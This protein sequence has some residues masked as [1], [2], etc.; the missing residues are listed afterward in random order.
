MGRETR[1][2][3]LV[4]ALPNRKRTE[5]YNFFLH[6]HFILLFPKF[7]VLNFW[8]CIPLAVWLS[9]TEEAGTI[10]WRPFYSPFLSPS[11]KYSLLLFGLSSTPR[12]SFAFSTTV[13]WN[14]S[15]P[16]I[17]W[18]DC[19]SLGQ[20]SISLFTYSQNTPSHLV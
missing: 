9:L 1:C 7:I 15:V 2:V 12:R 20:K 14:G 18:R 16:Y 5:T 13:I 17:K 10:L 4:E 6:V 8:F 19:C 3:T 11:P